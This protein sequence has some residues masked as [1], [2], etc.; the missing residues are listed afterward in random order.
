MQHTGRFPPPRPT[1]TRLC[2]GVLLPAPTTTV[3]TQSLPFTPK[4]LTVTFS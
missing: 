1:Q 3:S 4:T 2:G